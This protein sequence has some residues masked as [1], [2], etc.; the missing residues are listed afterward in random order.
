MSYRKVDPHCN[1]CGKSKAERSPDCPMYHGSKVTGVKYHE[2][3][4]CDECGFSKEVPFYMETHRAI[5]KFWRGWVRIGG[6]KKRDVCPT[7]VERG[8]SVRIDAST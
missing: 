7:C 4:Q 2:Y 8:V 3:L 5:E 6:N 1:W